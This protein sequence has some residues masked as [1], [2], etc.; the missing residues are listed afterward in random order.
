MM[1]HEEQ[2]RKLGQNHCAICGKDYDE[3]G[4]NADPVK[5]GRRCC[6]KCNATFVIPARIRAARAEA[7]EQRP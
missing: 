2:K 7:N 5:T 4:H 1:R 3:H 6:N